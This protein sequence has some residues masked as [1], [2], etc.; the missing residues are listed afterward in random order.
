MV[1]DG[2]WS[3][4]G[5]CNIDDRSFLLSYECNV[6]AFDEEFGTAVEAMFTEDLMESREISLKRWAKRSWWKRFKIKLLTPIIKQL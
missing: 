2:I 6:T 5:S 3:T 4:L 1:I